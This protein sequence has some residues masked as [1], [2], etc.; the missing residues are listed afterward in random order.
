MRYLSL[1]FA[2]C[3]LLLLSC[4]D[5]PIPAAEEKEE[6][7]NPD[8]PVGTDRD[9]ALP[10]LQV[11]GR[12]LR[13]EAG[14]VVNL[15][16]FAQTYS[17]FFNQNAWNNYDVAGCLRYNQRLID[18]ILAAGWKMNFVR[19]H[20]DPY[21]SDDPSKPAVRYEGHERFSTSRFKK[22]LEEVFIPMAEYANEKGLY[23]VFRPP[24]VSPEKI[25]VG[26]DYNLFLEEVWSIISSHPK[27][28]NNNGIMFELANEP[29][30]ILGSDGTHGSNGQGHF[31]RMKTFCQRIVDKIRAHANNIIWVPG[32]AY[33]SSFSGF[34]NNPVEG[35]NIG[36]AV[37]A[38]P[39]WYGS[40]TEEAS[41]E[42][43]GSIGG[44]YESFQQGWNAQ[45]KP[46]A[47]FAPIM[48][49]E[50]DWAPAKYDA[51]W[52]KSFTGT[53]GGPGF[54]ANFKYIADMTGNV[55]WLL[56]TECHR[57]A[58]FNNTP[59]TPG[60]YTFLNDPEAC[61]WP[62]YHWFREY[63]AEN[64]ETAAA[65]EKL[66]IVGVNNELQILTGGERYLITVATYADGSTRYVTA[67][68]RFRVSDESVLQISGNGI[69]T[70]LKDGTAIVT[71]AYT[72]TEGT[73]REAAVSIRAT[74]FPLT[75]ELF[76]PSI[77]GD[78]S[79]N[80]ETK[81]LITGQWGFGGWWYNKGVNLS[82]YQYLVAELGN[83]NESGVSF[84]L[85]DENNYWSQP[86]L[87]DFGSE[88]RVV[89]DLH[90]M[91]KQVGGQQV[92][93]DPSHIYIIGFWSSG[94]KP[95]VIKDVY[96]TDKPT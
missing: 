34:A 51:S 47:D 13:N 60:Q 31:D 76:N 85:F 32:L 6:S 80:E 84:R 73:T 61:P 95:I 27:I 92:K 35:T 53:V 90:N 5:T 21:W 91:Y 66:E 43:G 36:Y 23:V 1:L 52:G 3:S 75:A 93:L 62:T 45:V 89:V 9:T 63:A 59:G 65:L 48:V 25:A 2:L 29:I 22:Y 19:M 83:D 30:N 71:A 38:Y 81:T 96:L 28:K 46:V 16:G 49:T 70:A 14:E 41:I 86:A 58:V 26:D 56:F 57:L 8:S 87:Y 15:H 55:S 54:G 44:G 39:G 78:G 17:P 42:L 64:S 68:T 88:R 24:G 94:G 20:M 69:V 77:F 72:S 67:D 37:H 50:M 4:D 18:D 82:G 40:D 33:Q 12:Y 10:K 11:T 7:T 74:T 79:F